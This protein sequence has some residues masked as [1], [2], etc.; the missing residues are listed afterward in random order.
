MTEFHECVEIGDQFGGRIA[1]P[2]RGQGGTQTDLGAR[3]TNALMEG[4]DG[5]VFN[6]RILDYFYDVY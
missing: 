2:I 4:L 1:K 6:G 5:H 3:R